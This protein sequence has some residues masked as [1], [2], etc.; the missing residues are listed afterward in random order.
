MQLIQPVWN[1]LS[2]PIQWQILRVIRNTSVFLFLRLNFFNFFFDFLFACC[3]CLFSLDIFFGC[4][5]FFT[6]KVGKSKKNKNL[7]HLSPKQGKKMIFF[8]KKL[9]Q[10]SYVYTLQ[11]KNGGGW[12]P[13]FP[14]WESPTGYVCYYPNIP[15]NL[16]LCSG[17]IILSLFFLI[18]N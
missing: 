13:N 17:K 18:I 6:N 1:R 9:D 5:S 12:G 7:I 8:S 3:T 4:L 14:G 15:V 16:I 11:P 2:I 10:K